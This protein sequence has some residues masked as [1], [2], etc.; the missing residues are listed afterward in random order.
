M[1]S[2]LRLTVT[3]KVNK[4]TPGLRFINANGKQRVTKNFD[5]STRKFRHLQESH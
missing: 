4:I 2:P 3:I 1:H 5:N